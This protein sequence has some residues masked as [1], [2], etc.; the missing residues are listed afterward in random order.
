VPDIRLEIMGKQNHEPGVYTI[1]PVAV[2]VG[3]ANVRIEVDVSDLTDP[4]LA[5]QIVP[6]LSLDGG[7]NWEVLM[8]FAL[9]GGV[10]DPKKNP[11]PKYPL[12]SSVEVWAARP[13][14]LD[15]DI[16]NV[17]RQ[18]RATLTLTPDGKLFPVSADFVLKG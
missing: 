4:D 17:D 13:D 12:I 7:K 15:K 10:P 1:G 18:V 11:D 3:L 9:R 8:T 2:P 16:Q 14:F 5:V 6:E